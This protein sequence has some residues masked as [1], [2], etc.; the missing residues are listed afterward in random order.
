MAASVTP[1][2]CRTP[3]TPV[4]AIEASSNNATAAKDND[5]ICHN[6]N[7]DK[8]SCSSN[9]NNT[10]QKTTLNSQEL[11]R[12]CGKTSEDLYELYHHPQYNHATTALP[13][14]RND[15]TMPSPFTTSSTTCY[16]SRT[17]KELS[18][19]AAAASLTSNSLTSNACPSNTTNVTTTTATFDSVAA[20]AKATAKGQSNM[21]NILQEMQIW[22]LQIKCNDGLPQR[23]CAKCTAQ[24]YMIHKFRRKCLKVQTQL[25][26]LFEEELMQQ[27]FQLKCQKEEQKRLLVVKEEQNDQQQPLQQSNEQEIVQTK[28]VATMPSELLMEHDAKSET[29]TT[30]TSATSINPMEKL[31]VVTSVE[32]VSATVTLANANNTK[33]QQQEQLKSTSVKDSVPLDINV[34]TLSETLTK[35]LPLVETDEELESQPVTGTTSECCKN[36]QFGSDKTSATEPLAKR[37]KSNSEY[38][39][40]TESSPSQDKWQEIKIKPLYVPEKTTQSDNTCQFAKLTEDTRPDAAAAADAVKQRNEMLKRRT[41]KKLVLTRSKSTTPETGGSLPLTKAALKSYSSISTRASSSACKEVTPGIGPSLKCKRLENLLNDNADN[42]E[43]L[44]KACAITFEDK[45][46]SEAALNKQ[47][48]LN[49]KKAHNE[50]V[51]K[52][53]ANSSEDK[54]DSEKVLNKQDALNVKKSHNDDNNN[55]EKHDTRQI[56]EDNSKN[57]SNNISCESFKANEKGHPLHKSRKI[58]KMSLNSKILAKLDQPL[59]CEEK[60]TMRRRRKC[61][62]TPNTKSA[63]Q[64]SETRETS[65]SKL[66]FNSTLPKSPLSSKNAKRRRNPEELEN[67]KTKSL[68]KDPEI[69]I[70]QQHPTNKQ[71]RL[72]GDSKML[73]ATNN[74]NSFFDKDKCN[75]KKDFS[76]STS[77]LLSKQCLNSASLRSTTFPSSSFVSLYSSTRPAAKKL[78]NESCKTLPM[79]DS[80]DIKWQHRRSQR[81]SSTS[82]TSSSS[83]LSSSSSSSSSGLSSTSDESDAGE[84]DDCDD[85]EVYYEANIYHRMSNNNNY[86]TPTNFWKTKAQMKVNLFAT[87]HSSLMTAETTNSSAKHD[88]NT[89]TGFITE[90]LRSQSLDDDDANETDGNIKSSCFPFNTSLC[91]GDNKTCDN[92]I[93]ADDEDEKDGN[94]AKVSIKKE[95]PEELPQKDVKLEKESQEEAATKNDSKL[96]IPMQ[97]EN[98]KQKPSTIVDEQPTTNTTTPMGSQ[99]T[100]A[101]SNHKPSVDNRRRPSMKLILQRRSSTRFTCLTKE[102]EYTRASTP[103]TSTSSSPVRK[104]K[105][106]LCEEDIMD[107]KATLSDSAESQDIISH[108]DGGNQI[109]PVSPGS[110]QEVESKRPPSATSQTE[111]NE[112]QMKT[113]T[114]DEVQLLHIAKS[115]MLD[116]MDTGSNDETTDKLHK[117]TPNDTSESNGNSSGTDF[118]PLLKEAESSE[119]EKETALQEQKLVIRVPLASLTQHFKRMHLAKE[120]LQ[121]DQNDHLKAENNNEKENSCKEILMES[122]GAPPVHAVDNEASSKEEDEGTTSQNPQGDI[123]AHINLDSDDELKTEDKMEVTPETLHKPIADS[124]TTKISDTNKKVE[125]EPKNETSTAVQDTQPP[126][127]AKGSQEDEAEEKLYLSEGTLKESASLIEDTTDRPIEK[128]EKQQEEGSPTEEESDSR[129]ANFDASPNLNELKEE[130]TD[131]TEENPKVPESF[132]P[133]LHSDPAPPIS[134]NSETVEHLNDAKLSSTSEISALHPDILELVQESESLTAGDGV[135]PFV[136][137]SSKITDF[138]NNFQA[139]CINSPDV[140]ESEINSMDVLPHL[141]HPSNNPNLSAEIRDVEDTLNGILNEMHDRDMYTPRSGENEDFLAHSSIYSPMT[142][143]PTTPSQSLYAESPRTVNSNPMSLS[144]FIPSHMDYNAMTPQSSHSSCMSGHTNTT[145]TSSINSTSSQQSGGVSSDHLPS[146]TDCFAG[147]ESTQSELI[148]F[149]NDIP[150]FENIELNAN[151]EPTNADMG[152]MSND[153]EAVVNQATSKEYSNIDLLESLDK[154]NET[155]LAEFPTEGAL[156]PGTSSAL[157]D[158]VGIVPAAV[159]NAASAMENPD[160]ENLAAPNLT[161]KEDVSTEQHANEAMPTTEMDITQA[162]AHDINATND[163]V[164][165]PAIQYEAEPNT[166]PTVIDITDSSEQYEPPEDPNAATIIQTDMNLTSGEPALMH[167]QYVLTTTPHGPVFITTPQEIPQPAQSQNLQYVTLDGSSATSELSW[168]NQATPPAAATYFVNTSGEIFLSNPAFNTLVVP[169]PQQTPP[170]AADNYVQVYQGHHAAPPQQQQQQHQQ[171]QQQN[172]NNTFVMVVN[173]LATGE[174]QYIANPT[175]NST[176]LLQTQMPSNYISNSSCQNQSNQD[177]ITNENVVNPFSVNTSTPA[178]HASVSVDPCNEEEQ[179]TERSAAPSSPPSQRETTRQGVQKL[180]QQKI[181]QKPLLPRASTS[182]PNPVRIPLRSQKI[183]LICRFCHKR[184]KFTNNV[185][186]SNH[187]ITMHPAE[188]PYNCDYCPKHF[189]RRSERQDHV[190]QVHGS[191]YQCAQCGVSFCA[192]RALDFHLQKFHASSMPCAIPPRIAAVA[193]TQQILSTSTSTSSASSSALAV[194]HLQHNSTSTSSSTSLSSAASSQSSAYNLLHSAAQRQRLVRVA[195]EKMHNAQ[196]H[197]ENEEEGSKHKNHGSNN[198]YS[199]DSQLDIADGTTVTAPHRHHH[200]Q[201]KQ[202]HHQQQQQYYKQQPTRKLCC[203]DCDGD[204]DSCCS[205]KNNLQNNHKQLFNHHQQQQQFIGGNLND[206]VHN[207]MISIEQTEPDSTTTLRHF[208]KASL[209]S[210][211]SSEGMNCSGGNN[212]LPYSSCPYDSGNKRCVPSANATTQYYTVGKY[213]SR[214]YNCHLC[215]D[216]FA[217]ANALRKHRNVVH[218]NHCTMPFVCSICKRGFRLR[219]ALQRHMETHDAEG[220]PYGC[221]IC[222]VRFPRPSQ[223]TLHKL[224]VHKF[225]KVHTCDEC[226]KQF[227][228]ESSLKAH[229]KVAHEANSMPLPFACVYLEEPKYQ[230]PNITNN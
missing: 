90:G 76:I 223:L 61:S 84:V 208:R 201:T 109:L 11:C 192:Q 179:E 70:T 230:Q 51:T 188:K 37:R 169:P 114:E 92:G 31:T 106:K 6:D 198:K 211:A 60:E 226:G 23:I 55:N 116:D 170:V 86:R 73:L 147:E 65:P 164:S 108:E 173:N 10:A 187:I 100:N 206:G 3:K 49:V 175:A 75:M 16:G 39:H 205:V 88:L 68:S 119:Q 153:D 120:K 146:Y 93:D 207:T 229:E 167:Q 82:S 40:H 133:E 96:G 131:L 209:K 33:D 139:N 72:D 136:G 47:N 157:P 174:Q 195:E 22:H 35:D 145:I 185:D 105:R 177:V 143:A 135:K 14:S 45:P 172:P 97:D 101:A 152:E 123:V 202:L 57:V 69:E 24:F 118:P 216:S 212:Y 161:E 159:E 210:L 7:S 190:A 43:E 98:S 27:Q 217:T 218:N 13:Q 155:D 115:P 221:N 4:S 137:A 204:D 197:S 228:T 150:C 128:L 191:R 71:P 122:Y 154:T 121:E 99:S 63:S 79:Y 138:I 44:A 178:Q 171:S 140:A 158:L 227:G 213:V 9:N 149:Q 107:S 54:P 156:Q 58:S 199:F 182:S 219:N 183:S 41:R 28:E 94:P 83:L 19:A 17:D 130:V 224:T 125:E 163:D 129:E 166:A 89:S 38:D 18:V 77:K 64:C 180:L 81:L 62:R 189:Q 87:G 36:P 42:N 162:K 85:D 194:N 56:S 124:E 134:T 127:P 222:Q 53:C 34:D 29:I 196:H 148:G 117:L 151:G 80:T 52:A 67:K 91:L 15:E 215:E 50:Q 113:N 220:R 26:S 104:E 25:R 126:F 203:P 184:P 46:D 112:Q 32:D 214:D 66:A 144:P 193:P 141:T 160:S 74:Q 111:N 59:P 103:P 5:N 8:K 30:T 168:P 1:T 20:T 186:Y 78:L 21:E 132:K 95:E 2:L 102:E 48:A 176:V 225:E 200:H 12:S 165:E 142:D 181:Q 110:N